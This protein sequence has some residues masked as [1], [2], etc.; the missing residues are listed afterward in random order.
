M[1]T[2]SDFK[3]TAGAGGASQ[4]FIINGGM[5]VDQHY[6]ID[7][8]TGMGDGDPSYLADL[9]ELFQ[10]GS[11]SARWTGSNEVGGGVDGNSNWIKALNTTADASPGDE[12]QMFMQKIEAQ[13]CLPMLDSAGD[14]KALKFAF[15]IIAHADGASS[16]TF[17]AKAAVFFLPQDGTQRQ[18]ISEVTITAADTW[19]RVEATIVADTVTSFVNDNGVGVYVGV[20]LYGGTLRQATVDTW[21]NNDNDFVTSTSDNWAD[22]TSNYLGITNVTLVSAS[23]AS[24][25]VPEPYGDTLQKCLRYFWL[26][27][28]G[29]NKVSGTGTV[30]N[31]TTA[32]VY[33]PYPVP[34]RDAA[35]QYDSTVS[36]FY[37]YAEGTAFNPTN[38]ATNG[39]TNE[40][41]MGLSLTK[42]GMTGTGS[43]CWLVSTGGSSRLYFTAEL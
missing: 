21:A 14:L 15:D 43:G 37:F 27:L 25:Y 9:W 26:A 22:A 29:V 42:T 13:N 8:R 41:G 23:Q 33:I 38:I 30:Q 2:Y 20:S 11:A 39:Y 28:A 6:D 18:F 10:Y 36:H 5:A 17:P 31:S 24:A 3:A 7:T 19:E 35:T 12:G 16:I 1:S 4:S 34:M 40:F 32:Y